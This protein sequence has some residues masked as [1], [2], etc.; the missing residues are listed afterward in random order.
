M[1]KLDTK[2]VVTKYISEIDF[3]SSGKQGDVIEIGL[4]FKN[5]GRTSISFSCEVRNVFTKEI[6]IRIENIVFVMV[7]ENGKA[8]PHGKKLQNLN[9]NQQ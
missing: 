1:T 5:V 8:V 6:I 2:N 7:D 9:L 3:I 4:G